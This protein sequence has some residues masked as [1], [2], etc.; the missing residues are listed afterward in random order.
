MKILEVLTC[1]HPSMDIIHQEV[2]YERSRI[3]GRPSQ[4]PL[5]VHGDA[6]KTKDDHSTTPEGTKVA[7]WI[8]IW[9]DKATA[10]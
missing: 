5:T 8:K 6:I 2:I 7:K 4:N 9:I 1:M 10:S 3:V